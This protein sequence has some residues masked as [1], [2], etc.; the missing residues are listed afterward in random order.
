MI[1]ENNITR[2]VPALVC[3][4]LMLGLCGCR[5]HV[6]VS[7][8]PP[9]LT[10]VPLVEVPRP[11]DAPMLTPPHIKMP[12]MPVAAAAARLPRERRR[13]VVKDEAPPPVVSPTPAQEAATIGSLTAG[14][15][16]SSQT[17]Q[18]AANL[19]ASN[20]RRL[21]GLSAQKAEQQKDEVNTVKNF[22][23]QAQDALGSGDAEGAMTLATKAKL[24]LDD[25]EK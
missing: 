19:I 24:L 6:R 13:P 1:C 17:R 9:V 3:A 14:G 23:K 10:P 18:D 4:G 8:L 15:T 7:P 16:G 11:A 21:N 12:P 22:E 25:L 2:K 5:H 20:E